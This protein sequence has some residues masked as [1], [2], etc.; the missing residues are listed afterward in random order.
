MPRRQKKITLSELR[1]GIFMLIALLVTAFLI[2]NS[3]GNFNPF[4]QKMRL[5]SRFE[6]ADGLHAGAD[7]KLAGV[8]IGKVENVK[9]LPPDSPPGERVEATLAIKQ[10]LDKKPIDELIRT[11]SRAQ[12]TGTSVL[13][14]DKMINIVPGTSKGSPIAEGAL[15]PS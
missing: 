15:L 3:S 6:N 9:F 10:T 2:L 8:S 4:Q 12:M 11:D 1:V 5:R 14:N 13:G 7:V